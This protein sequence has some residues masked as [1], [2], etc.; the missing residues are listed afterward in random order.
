MNKVISIIIIFLF[1]LVQTVIACDPN[2]DDASKI[3]EKSYGDPNS[4]NQEGFYRNADLAN[5][6]FDW[7]KVDWDNEGLQSRLRSDGIAQDA[8]FNRFGYSNNKIISKTKDSQL[9]FKAEKLSLVSGSKRFSVTPRDYGDAVLYVV[10]DKGIKIILP[11][12]GSVDKVSNDDYVFIETNNNEPIDDEILVNGEFLKDGDSYWLNPK[13]TDPDHKI[14][15]RGK[16]FSNHGDKPIKLNFDNSI[17]VSEDIINQYQEN[18]DNLDENSINFFKDFYIV[19]CDKLIIDGDNEGNMNYPIFYTQND[20]S[21]A[22]IIDERPI[23]STF[24]IRPDEDGK[25]YAFTQIGKIPTESSNKW[26]D[27]NKLN[28]QDIINWIHENGKYDAKRLDELSEALGLK[29]KLKFSQLVDDP[30]GFIRIPDSKRLF[31]LGGNMNIVPKGIRV[32]DEKVYETPKGQLKF[33]D[34]HPFLGPT[35]LGIDDVPTDQ[36]RSPM[37]MEINN[38]KS[39]YPIVDGKADIN[40]LKV[41][42]K[43]DKEITNQDILNYLYIDN[44]PKNV[45]ARNDELNKKLGKQIIVKKLTD[46]RKGNFLDT[47]A[48]SETLDVTVNKNSHNYEKKG[49]NSKSGV[50]SRKTETKDKKYDIKYDGKTP[51]QIWWD[52]LDSGYQN[53]FR[54]KGTGVLCVGDEVKFLP[55]DSY[56]IRD[57]ELVPRD[58]LLGLFEVESHYEPGKGFVINAIGIDKNANV[59]LGQHNLLYIEERQQILKEVLPEA[60]FDPTNARHN[61]IATAGLLNRFLKKYKGDIEMALTAYNWGPTFVDNKGVKASPLRTKKYVKEILDKCNCKEMI[62]QRWKDTYE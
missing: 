43:N 25:Y 46:D 26:S 21:N 61:I 35:G 55:R 30:G 31:F 48:A 59:G 51:S 1:G 39:A 24:T 12:G 22:L 56:L 6:N 17:S 19:K 5:E 37:T 16:T 23:I 4:Y 27:K 2:C 53:I 38:K 9:D 11:N 62:K 41:K 57:R 44:D 18:I 34:L 13:K 58:L 45:R 49:S 8:Y 15:V 60:T 28:N 47:I 10:T 32:I 42:T 54:D 20:K 33:G 36:T 7:S 3:T 52:G 40:G 29:E 14:S 50:N